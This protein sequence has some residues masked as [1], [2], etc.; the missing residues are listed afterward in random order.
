MLDG[1]HKAL[2]L[3]DSPNCASLGRLVEG[4]GYKFWWE[5]DQCWFCNPHGVWSQ[6]SVHNYVPFLEPPDG[7]GSDSEYSAIVE[8][9]VSSLG[10]DNP[11]LPNVLDDFARIW[12]EYTAFVAEER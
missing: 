6:L 5:K 9:C 7:P 1:M 12:P 11:M 8:W 4:L 3:P 10:A 2:M